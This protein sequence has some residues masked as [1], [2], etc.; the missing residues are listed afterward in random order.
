M[1][2]YTGVS[3][4]GLPEPGTRDFVPRL[5]QMLGTIDYYLHDLNRGIARIQN[6]QIP[7]GSGDPLGGGITIPNE[8]GSVLFVGPGP[9]LDTDGTNFYYDDTNNRLGLKTSPD[10]ASLH[11]FQEN[12]TPAAV[13]EYAGGWGIVDGMGG[14]DASVAVRTSDG[15][16]S[17][18]EGATSLTGAVIGTEVT[19]VIPSNSTFTGWKI[20]FVTKQVNAGTIPNDTVDVYINRSY[21]ANVYTSGSLQISLGANWLRNQVQGNTAYADYV[22]NISASDALVL[23]GAT[24]ISILLTSNGFSGTGTAAERITYMYIETPADGSSGDPLQ[25]WSYASSYNLLGYNAGKLQLTGTPNLKIATTGLEFNIGTPAANKFWVATDSVGTGAWTSL[26]SITPAEFV[27]SAFRIIGSATSTKKLA[28]EVDGFTAATTRTL[29]PQDASYTIAGLETANV[30]T[31]TQRIGP[32]SDITCL[33]L[34]LTNTPT[35]N[36]ITVNDGSN[37]ILTLNGT[38]L[39]VIDF[40]VN[41]GTIGS[42]NSAAFTSA[43]LAG[44]RNIGIPDVSGTMV[45][46]VAGANIGTNR[47]P[48]FNNTNPTGQLATSSTFTYTTGTSTLS[49]TNVA[50]VTGVT[51]YKGVSTVRAGVASL[52]ATSTL[53][54]QSAAIGATTIYAVPAA[55]A[56]MYRISWVASVTTAATTSCILGGANGF[57]VVYT[58][59][60]DSVAKTSNPTTVTAHTSAVN[61]TATTV[62]GVVVAKCKLSTN[63][64]YSFDYTS[65]GGTAMVYD[66]DIAVEFLG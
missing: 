13:D 17:Y 57:Q 33:Y 41:Q 30:F 43:L 8:V 29:T 11:I 34:D 40:T 16:T 5:R 62:S 2:D 31:T 15:D 45:T 44:A 63:L 22:Y 46:R 49:V 59:P 55:G 4:A 14:G 12:V 28:F 38:V 25:K 7:D 26:S 6:G 23:S 32:T 48:F 53:T 39:N 52:V 24:R 50:V 51:S 35:A 36:S 47:V 58:D 3:W 64:Q 54:A 42:G 37:N 18:I 61:A 21:A 1:R 10:T 66:L 27:D 9:V 60:T 20:H 56:G 65:V 19:M